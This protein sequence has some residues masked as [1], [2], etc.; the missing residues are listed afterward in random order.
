MRPREVGDEGDDDF[1]IRVNACDGA[2]RLGEKV[3]RDVGL[4]DEVSDRLNSSALAL[5]GGQQQRL[6]IAR[7][8]ALDP[9]V[10]LFDEPCSA[11][12][13]ISCSVVEELIASLRRQYT[14]VIVTHNMSQARRIAD[15]V[16]VF[17]VQEGSG[18]I[19]EHGDLERVFE[20]P[21]HAIV[22]DYVQGGC[23]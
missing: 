3:I 8:M 19:I 16:A 9:D 7:A 22:K 1:W 10:L 23:G 6:C 17:W 4:W 14:V 2:I 12:D 5:S 15:S 18:R 13:P 11:L 20:D 21:K